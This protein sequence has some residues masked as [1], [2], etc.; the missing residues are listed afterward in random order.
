MK[1]FSDEELYLLS[2]GW[3]YEDKCTYHVW[4]N[5]DKDGIAFNT[6]VYAMNHGED[7][8]AHSRKAYV[9]SVLKAIDEQK[10]IEMSD[11]SNED[12]RSEL[13]RRVRE[14]I[15]IVGKVTESPTVVER[16]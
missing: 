11:M 10:K 12:A 9:S 16:Y 6:W 15:A 14:R 13:V 8:N 3:R 7:Y 2:R 5:H 4:V 1:Y